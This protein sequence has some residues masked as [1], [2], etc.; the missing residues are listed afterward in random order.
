MNLAREVG[1]VLNPA[2]L[3]HRKERQVNTEVYDYDN[4]IKQDAKKLKRAF[5]FALTA[6]VLAWTAIVGGISFIA[7]SVLKYFVI[8]G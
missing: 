5:W 8:A 2:Y 1:R 6:T 7:Y 4:R 3:V